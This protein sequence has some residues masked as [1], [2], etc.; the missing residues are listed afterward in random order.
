MEAWYP[1]TGSPWNSPASKTEQEVH[2]Q[3]GQARPGGYVIFLAR[4]WFWPLDLRIPPKTL[5]YLTL[6]HGSSAGKN[7]YMMQREKS[8]GRQGLGRQAVPHTRMSCKGRLLFMAEMLWLWVIYPES[9]LDTSVQ[10]SDFLPDGSKSNV[11]KGCFFLNGSKTLY[12][13]LHGASP[14]LMTPEETQGAEGNS[15]SRVP[16][17][18]RDWEVTEEPDRGGLLPGNRP[19]SY[20]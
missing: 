16:W 8:P 7:T 11:R 4:C 17:R 18:R 10:D 2:I 9:F 12:R 13:L 14:L 1:L 6:S 15:G 20:I 19:G 3:R 5:R